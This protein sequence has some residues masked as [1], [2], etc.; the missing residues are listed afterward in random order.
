MICGWQE[1]KFYMA[2]SSHKTL[3]KDLF[4]NDRSHL[5]AGS[6]IQIYISIYITLIFMPC[7]LVCAE[8]ICC[9]LAFQGYNS[10]AYNRTA[11]YWCVVCIQT[12]LVFVVYVEL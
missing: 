3:L 10:L 12:T 1:E 7:A 4:K 9:I 2:I 5:R 8:D 11:L 6:P